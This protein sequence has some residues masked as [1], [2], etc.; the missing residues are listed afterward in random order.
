MPRFSRFSIRELMLLTVVVGFGIAWWIEHR[1]AAELREENSLYENDL[2]QMTATLE[3]A[4]DAA[5][6]K[7]TAKALAEG[8]MVMLPIYVDAG[9]AQIRTRSLDGATKEK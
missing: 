5:N 8:K 9:E 3:E 2:K 6:E 4:L 1:Q 7:V